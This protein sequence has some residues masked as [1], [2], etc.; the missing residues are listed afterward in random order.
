MSKGNKMPNGTDKMVAKRVAEDLGVSISTVSRAF[1]PTAVI[2]RGTR[3][4]VLAR[5]KELGYQPNPFAQSLITQRSRIAGIIVS[6]ITNPFYP[7]VLTGMTEALQNEGLNVML[8][9]GTS[10]RGADDMVPLALRYRPDV[11]VV[12]AATISSRAAVEAAE[13]GTRVIFFNRYVPGVAALSVTCD[14]V[15]GGRQVADH[16]IDLGHRRLAFVAG[17][18]DA[19]TSVER[20]RGFAERCAERGLPTPLKEEAGVFTHDTGYAA[21]LRLLSLKDRPDAIFCANDILALG[22]LDA[23]ASLGL[24]APGDLSVVGFDDISMATWPSY[25]LTTYRQPVRRM[26]AATM[27]LAR[28]IIAGDGEPPQSRCIAGHLVERNTTRKRHE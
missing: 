27:E 16:L 21:A 15:L 26:I 6:D 1:S 19:T 9:A 4:R 11:I 24:K 7:E 14:N 22:A 20:W 28:Q 8:F 13:A 18:L 3:E 25:S 17:L 12:M 10:A 23:M 2:A 5:A